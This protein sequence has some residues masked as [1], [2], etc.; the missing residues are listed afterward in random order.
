[1]TDSN[2]CMAGPLTPHDYQPRYDEREPDAFFSAFSWNDNKVKKDKIWVADVCS[3]CGHVIPR[4][5]A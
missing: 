3:Q 5:R 4:R 2:G 1:M